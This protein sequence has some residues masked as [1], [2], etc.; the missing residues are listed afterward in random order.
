MMVNIQVDHFTVFLNLVSKT[1]KTDYFRIL[2]I[3]IL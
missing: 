3:N 2:M 1:S